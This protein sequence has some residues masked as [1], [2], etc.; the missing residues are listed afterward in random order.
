MKQNVT[1][2]LKDARASRN[3]ENKLRNVTSIVDLQFPDIA[4]LARSLER[5]SR[6]EDKFATS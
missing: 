4:A 1:D 6:N 5:P 3:S 2:M